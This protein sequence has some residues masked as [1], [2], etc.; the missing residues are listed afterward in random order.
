MVKLFI[1]SIV[2]QAACIEGETGIGKTSSSV[3]FSLSKPFNKGY[4]LLNFSE[5]TKISDTFGNITVIDNQIQHIDKPLTI[6]MKQGNVFIADE[7]NISKI[8][9][10]CA[11]ALERDINKKV[12][13]PGTGE[14]IK[15]HPGFQFIICQNEITTIGRKEIPPSIASKII[16]I[17]YPNSDLDLIESICLNIA[18]NIISTHGKFT[19][20]HKSFAK[21]LANKKTI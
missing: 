17:K 14:K 5:G 4:Q 10:S 13:I 3:V 7:F 2:Q 18:D 9:D 16:K 8:M 11:I 19:D 20:D 15:I 1:C 12:I 6:S 21:N